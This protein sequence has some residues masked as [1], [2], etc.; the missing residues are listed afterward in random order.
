[1]GR[2]VAPKVL[3]TT[4]AAIYNNTFHGLSSLDGEVDPTNTFFSYE[5]CHLAG[6]D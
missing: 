2:L 5:H 1:V 4:F 6:A 3:S